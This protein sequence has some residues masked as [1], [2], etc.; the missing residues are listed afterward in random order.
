LVGHSLIPWF[1]VTAALLSRRSLGTG[2]IGL[3]DVAA[4]IVGL[5]FGSRS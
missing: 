5:Y 4:A 1:V 2:K 3:P